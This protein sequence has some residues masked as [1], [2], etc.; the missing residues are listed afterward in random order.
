[1]KDGEPS[2]S[3]GKIAVRCARAGAAAGFLVVA[4]FLSLPLD[5]AIDRQDADAAP[6][7][8]VIDRNFAGVVALDDDD[9][10]EAAGVERVA[11]A[12]DAPAEITAA[13]AHSAESA[14]SQAPAPWP[15]KELGLMD[16]VQDWLA[17]ANREFQTIIVRRLSVAPAG[18]GGDAIARKIEEAKEEDAEAGRQRREAAIKAAQAKQDAEAKRLTDAAEAKKRAEE[19]RKERERLE[20][21][22]KRIEDQQKLVEDKRKAEEQKRIE[23]AGRAAQAAQD[24][25]AKKAAAEAQAAKERGL[26]E[27]AAEDQRERAEEAHQRALADA[28]AKAVEDAKR[29]AAAQAAEE[30]A[31]QE[32]AAR[33]VAENQRLA[34]EASA[35]AA[36]EKAQQEAA[37]KEA[38]DRQRAAEQEATKAAA[39]K[40]AAVKA[41]QEKTA[42]SP[43]PPESKTESTTAATAPLHE[44]RIVRDANDHM[45][46]GPVVQRWIRR[47]R[48]GRCRAE[49]RKILLPGH[50]VV[51]RG[52]SL[53]RIA[54]RHYRSGLYFLRIYRANRDVIRDPNRI[55]PCERLYLPRRR[56]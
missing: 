35:K 55:Y 5:A 43:E 31:K 50:Y 16:R 15:G 3:A 40:A 19:K 42:A 14:K 23:E 22:S 6:D 11:L 29:T 41:A 49:G 38:A 8:A 39:A 32:A 18:G 13:D 54:L 46:R 25:I 44:A 33:R 34:E 36:E 52:D 2:E 45:A 7:R 53:W 47:A 28:A 24:A 26:A 21:E 48:Q 12:Q 27:K 37:A 9:T 30:K 4:G 10:L 17:R 51:A 20:A 1:M 56:G